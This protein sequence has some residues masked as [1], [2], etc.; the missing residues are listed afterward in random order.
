M[1]EG[2]TVGPAFRLYAADVPLAQQLQQEEPGFTRWVRGQVAMQ[3]GSHEQVLAVQDQ[4]PELAYDMAAL[5]EGPAGNATLF[6]I[7]TWAMYE[8]PPISEESTCRTRRPR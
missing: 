7:H 6:Q 2:G 1:C 8:E 4:N 5:P 3:Q